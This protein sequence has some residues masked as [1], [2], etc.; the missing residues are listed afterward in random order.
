MEDEES[1]LWIYKTIF[2][3]IFYAYYS[4]KT[5]PNSQVRVSANFFLKTGSVVA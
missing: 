4:L 5:I 1:M 2:W 3:K